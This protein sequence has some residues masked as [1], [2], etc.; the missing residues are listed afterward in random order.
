MGSPNATEEAAAR[1]GLIGDNQAPEHNHSKVLMDDGTINISQS[2]VQT[3]RRCRRA[4]HNKFVLLL[5]KK[6]RKRPFM[7]GGI[8]HEVIE[9]QLEGHKWKKV[10][11]KIEL[12]NKKLFRREIEMYGDIINDIRWIMKDYF[13]F[14]DGQFKPFEHDGRHSEWEFRIELD[15]GLW[16][17][18][19][20]D[21][22]GKSKKLK[23]LVEHK[24]FARMPSE[25]DRWRSVQAAV[26][27]KAAEMIGLPSI[28][29]VMW[30]YISSKPV[31][32]PGQLTATGK[33]SQARL[34]TTPSRIKDWLE[35]HGKK[36]KDFP[37]LIKDAEDNQRN[38]FIRL[39]SPIKPRVVD[40]IWVDFVDTAKEIQ[41]YHG[42]KKDQ[43]I[44]RHCSW[45]DYQM[46][47]KAEATDSDL[48]WI[49]KREYQ[50][51]DQS[52]KAAAAERE[53]D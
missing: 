21:T 5:Q 18:G 11:A 38:R 4:Y 52:H 50:T 48:E 53:E 32:F 9:A 3:W 8:V 51:E 31:M 12:D 13:N 1:A 22:A 15:T 39:Y 35:E 46:L 45:C 6:K 47:C 26:Y 28:D 24:T 16:F 14:W 37:K 29:G 25:D 43:S 41:E 33:I 49:L 7:F 34:D 19:K 10:L 23:W 30:D 42:K 20:I 36:P 2:K 44:G 17:T 27:F 40:T